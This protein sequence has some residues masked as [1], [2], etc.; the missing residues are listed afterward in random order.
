MTPNPGGHFAANSRANPWPGA[1][2]ACAP[3]V[4]FSLENWSKNHHMAILIGSCTP[5]GWYE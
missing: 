3:H 2:F 1:I 4:P 5:G